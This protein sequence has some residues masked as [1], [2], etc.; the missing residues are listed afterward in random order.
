MERL[1]LLFAVV[2]GSAAQAQ[3]LVPNPSFEEYELCPDFHQIIYVTGWNESF[4]NSPDYFNACAEGS[5]G[6]VPLN[7]MGY[8]LP[9]DGDAYAGLATFAYNDYD[10]REILIIELLQPL[11]VGI[12]TRISFATSCGGFGSLYYN[13][14]KWKAR[15]PGLKFFIEP[16]SDWSAYLYPNS[17]AVHMD[18][19]LSDTASWTTVS[20]N[21]IP[22]SAYRFLAITNFYEDSLSWPSIQ[23]TVFGTLPGSYAFIDDV[24][25]SQ[26]SSFCGNHIGMDEPG[27][28]QPFVFPN[29]VAKELHVILPS[30]S[31]AMTISIHDIAGRLMHKY[32]S[33]SSSRDPTLDVS[34]LPEGVYVLHVADGANS[35]APVRF[36]H[37]TP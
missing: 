7:G 20:G 24:C 14:A 19:V 18:S 37:V 11:E 30:S 15:G 29:P 6:G 4:F 17:A 9:A 34:T 32:Q 23:D 3:N 12:P 16:P 35:F 13:S 33:A 36:V 21:Y 2:L 28:F 27:H 8:Q 10:Y 5:P 25:V 26:S 31:T 22:D 1:P